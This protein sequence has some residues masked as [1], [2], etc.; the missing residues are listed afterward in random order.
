MQYV[1]SGKIKTGSAGN[2]AGPANEND[3]PPALRSVPNQDAATGNAP[4]SNH[5]LTF[6]DTRVRYDE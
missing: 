5:S 4:P 6:D 2:D 1:F 3:S